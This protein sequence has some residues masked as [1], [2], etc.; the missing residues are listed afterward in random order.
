MPDLIIHID[1]SILLRRS[2]FFVLSQTIPLMAEEPATITHQRCL[3]AQNNMKGFT[4][5]ELAIALM[6][7]GLLIGGI[8]KGQ[9]LVEN[10]RIT[11]LIKDITNYHTAQAIFESTYS[12]LPGDIRNPVTRIPNC[13]EAVC[14]LAG[15]Q[16]RIMDS[17]WESGNFTYHMQLAGMLSAGAVMISSYNGWQTRYFSLDSD[18]YWMSPEYKPRSMFNQLR[19]GMN[20]GTMD[21]RFPEGLDTKLDDGKPRSGS[22]AMNANCIGAGGQYANWNTGASGCEIFMDIPGLSNPRNGGP[23]F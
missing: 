18:T 21:R 17:Y 23:V 6:V 20:T 14:Q 10:A 15:N 5:V 22:I 13:T 3:S 4:L 9:E 16:N 19:L 12:A 11:R 1:Q 8:L 7:I 2:M